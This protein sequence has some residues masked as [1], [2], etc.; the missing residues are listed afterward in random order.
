MIVQ[1]K[2]TKY[3]NREARTVVINL[4]IPLFASI[5][6]DEAVILQ[7]DVLHVQPQEKAI[8][9]A[10]L[11]D[12]RAILYLSLLCCKTQG[13]EKHDERDKTPQIVSI[14]HF[15]NVS[16]WGFIAQIIV[17]GDYGEKSQQNLCHNH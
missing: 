7:L 14:H 8:V 17:F 11:V 15:N 10:P 16:S 6:V 5:R 12:I 1:A 4:R 3:A 2:V 13:E 9:E